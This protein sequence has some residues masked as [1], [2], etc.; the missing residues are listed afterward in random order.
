[1]TITI[2]PAQSSD[3]AAAAQMQLLLWPDHSMEE[4]LMEME[5]V[6]LSSDSVVMLA[7][8]HEQPIGFAECRLRFD[9]V[10]GT[11][12]SPVGYL[13]GI[14][15]CENFRKLGVA[16]SLL[17]SCEKWAKDKNCSEFAS[18]CELV[19]EASINFHHQSGFHEVNRIVCFTKKL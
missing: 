19:N 6:I 8:Q 10:E 3:I 1:M 12:A 13:E 7:I 16:L 15:V 11:H 9:Y 17:K 5:R 2:R 18:D 14:Y 4:M